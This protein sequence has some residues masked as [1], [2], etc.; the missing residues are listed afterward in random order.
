MSYF[1]GIDIGTTGTRAVLID[2]QG[3]VIG[4]KSAEHDPISSPL[5]QWAEQDPENWWV[6]ARQAIMAVLESKGIKGTEVKGIGLSGQM[7]GLVL[8]DKDHRVLR[9][10]IIWC[11]Q[12]CQAEADLITGVVTYD[13]LI[14]ITCNPALT[15]FT[16]PK[17]IWVREHEP[18]VFSKI[19]RVLLPK[20]FIRFRL[21]GEFASEVSDSSGTSLFDVVNRRWSVE[22]MKTL[23]LNPEWFPT[24]RESIEISGRIHA[25]AARETGLEEGTPVA[26][27]GVTRPRVELA[28]A[29]W[30]P[31]SSL[32]RSELPG[33]F[34]PSWKN[35][36][37]ISGAASTPSAMLSPKNG[38]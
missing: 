2:G 13:R 20:D 5:P 8:L 10:S 9:P 29:S 32:A 16:A 33:W 36:P 18:E 30:N 6:A 11:D 14:E 37:A 35:Q 34:L 4:G 26:G 38:M 15:G 23:G 3:K 28:T 22:I 7:H 31:G 17:L 27:G 24:V 25:E 12:R 1:L 19:R 21:T